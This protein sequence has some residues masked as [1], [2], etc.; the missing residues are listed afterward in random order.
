MDRY[1]LIWIDNGIMFR[2][3][4]WSFLLHL[5]MFVEKQAAA[6]VCAI[7]SGE[8]ST[9]FHT[10]LQ[11]SFTDQSAYRLEAETRDETDKVRTN[12][13]SLLFRPSCN[14]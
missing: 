3:S 5:E 10:F 8:C 7:V 14:V 11:E 4:T 2:F 1:G 13:F 9:M 6:A 12:V